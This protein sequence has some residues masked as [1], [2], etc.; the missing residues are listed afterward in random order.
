VKRRTFQVEAFARNDQR[1]FSPIHNDRGAHR[2]IPWG[3]LVAMVLRSAGIRGA[4]V[5]RRNRLTYPVSAIIRPMTPDVCQVNFSC[6]RPR[7]PEFLA[8]VEKQIH[9]N[10]ITMVFLVLAL[11]P[12]G[13]QG[14]TELIITPHWREHVR[15]ARRSFGNAPAVFY[16]YPYSRG[17]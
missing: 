5:I 7:L 8:Q 3:D 16:H 6:R 11:D 1:Q 4:G 15:I 9:E 13:E 2:L 12:S 17:L 14:Q 10:T